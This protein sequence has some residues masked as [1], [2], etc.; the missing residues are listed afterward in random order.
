MHDEKFVGYSNSIR[1][2]VYWYTY[3]HGINHLN[4]KKDGFFIKH[5]FK[6]KIC[7]VSLSW[8]GDDDRS[9]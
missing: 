9:S 8:V 5:S 6:I 1:N 2:Q 3:K 4:N 7:V